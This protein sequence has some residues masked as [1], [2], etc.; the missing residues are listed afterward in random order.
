M[1][2]SL[3]TSHHAYGCSHIIGRGLHSRNGAA[4]I[5]PAI[6]ELIAKY[7]SRPHF[8]RSTLNFLVHRYNLVTS[9]DPLNTGLLIVSLNGR[10]RGGH[11]LEADELTRNL[12]K[13]GDG[14]LIM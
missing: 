7:A 1:E 13:Q 14:C 5:K 2:V 4:K 11:V 6:E 10:D 12:E 8:T 9:V 3:S